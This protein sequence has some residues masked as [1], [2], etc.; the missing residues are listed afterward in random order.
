M[1]NPRMTYFRIRTDEARQTPGHWLWLDRLYTRKTAIQLCTDIR[2]GRRIAGIL[3]GERFD[4]R[5]EPVSGTDDHY[6]AIRL[7]PTSNT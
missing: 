1:Y 5:H 4:A 2:A 6:V 7:I 3:E